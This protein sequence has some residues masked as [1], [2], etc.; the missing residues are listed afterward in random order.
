MNQP[1]VLQLFSAQFRRALFFS[2]LMFVLAVPILP[3]KAYASFPNRLYRIDIRPQKNFTRLTLRLADPPH[4]RLV[5]I[6]GNRLR[7]VIQ[8][9]GGT[10]FKKFRRYSDKNIGGLVLKQ[11]GN[12][13]LV[14][15]QFSQAAGWR[16][17]SRHDISAITVDIG[18][19]FR[20]GPPQPTL[21][22]REKIWEGVEKLVRNF[23]PPLKSEIPFS[24][25]DRQV[26]K[27]FLTDDEQK[28]F[29][30]AEAALYKGQL[31]EAEELF[32]RFAS[33]QTPI[34]PLALYRL[35]ETWYK[36]QK[37]SQALAA[38]HEAEKLWP[39][40]LG[41]NPGVTFYYG[42][43]IA[44]SGEVASARPLL[45]ALVVRLADKTYAPALLVR[46]GDI[47][48]RQ[49]HEHEALAIYQN[50]AENFKGNKA[51][52][53]ALMRVA[54]SGFLQSTRWN[55][56]S[57]SD[58][59]L[60]ASRQSGDLDM[61]EEAHF[62]YVLLE[63]IHGEAGEALQLVMS[64]QRKFP[65]GVYV[66][67]VRTIREVLVAEAYRDAEWNKDP[68]ALL[69][70]MDEQYEYLAGC[71]EQPGFLATVTRAYSEAGRP[72]E[73]VKLLTSLVERS[74]AAS[75]AP[76]LY[77]SIVDNAELIGDS[78]AAERNIKA[79][80]GK[81]STNP[82][83][84]MMTER[85]GSIYFSAGKYQQVKETLLWL[86]N[87]GERAQR[88]ESYYLLGRSLWELQ[89]YAQAARSMDLFLSTPSGRDPRTMPDAYFVAGSA[90]ESLGD[91]KGALKQFE[92]ALKLP[93]NSRND[94]FIYRAGQINLREGNTGR[95]KE[96][97]GQ[98]A[99]KGKDPDW[100]KLARQAL[101]TL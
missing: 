85:L 29:M 36:L 13:L 65:R 34:R 82:R 45:T 30:A 70:F 55:Y 73:L 1:L 24:P 5:A 3:A 31:T 93:D 69:R 66:A 83:A 52:Q 54:D 21:A 22:G 97:F 41:I 88:T 90:R 81:F 27:N 18:A 15:F 91:R 8:D 14:T 74:W 47:L 92:A 16:D 6:P 46:L 42:D 4:Y 39:A 71:V 12:S 7:L 62:K 50:V 100:Q 23:D 58:V 101:S 86:L 53:M 64:F 17:L 87:K 72:I 77:V 44:R 2:V 25:T 37:Y 78:A 63:S 59:Y 28:N 11:R 26:L 76:E 10:L 57:I 61:R 68:S 98:L 48:A 60:N 9:T 84:R 80:L 96:L 94:E 95:A 43:S 32:T 35:A 89:L 67:V 56:R 51:S 19:P 38:F 99:E 75:V 40:Y 79:F 20:P 33:S 49:G